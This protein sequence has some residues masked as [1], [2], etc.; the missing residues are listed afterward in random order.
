MFCLQS[1]NIFPIGDIAIVKAAKELTHVKTKEEV[2]FLSEHWKPFRS[3]ASY[4][5]WHY[6][7]C[8]R[9]KAPESFKERTL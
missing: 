8:K 4:Y 5:L 2:A 6:Y 1:K 9:S 7:L 3:L